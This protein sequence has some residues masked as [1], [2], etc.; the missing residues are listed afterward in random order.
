MASQVC[1][2]AGTK[3]NADE[4]SD[5]DSDEQPQKKASKKDAEYGVA[6][7]LDFRN[8]SFVLN[9]WFGKEG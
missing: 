3:K 8:V 7:G 6:R 2:E 5:S 4:E 1:N 9:G